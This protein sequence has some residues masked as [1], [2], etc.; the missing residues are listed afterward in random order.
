M[1]VRE[2][3]DSSGLDPECV[4]VKGRA[5]RAAPVCRRDERR[6]PERCQPG[7]LAQLP[8]ER[9]LERLAGLDG[10]ARELPVSGEPVVG[11]APEEHVAAGAAERESADDRSRRCDLWDG[12]HAG[13]TEASAGRRL[14]SQHVSR[15][16]DCRTLRRQVMRAEADRE[17]GNR[18]RFSMRGRRRSA[19]GLLSFTADRHRGRSRLRLL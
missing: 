12:R 3:R 4:L 17:R 8:P 10:A 7:L 5:V 9:P 16:T 1:F 18:S 13:E 19:F 15:G 14:A 11:R 2:R 6:R